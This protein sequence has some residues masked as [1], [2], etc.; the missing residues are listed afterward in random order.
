MG[1]GEPNGK[2]R[3]A[4]PNGGGGAS[5]SVQSEGAGESLLAALSG[6]EPSEDLV[7]HC[8]DNR[9]GLGVGCNGG[10]RFGRD[11]AAHARTPFAVVAQLAFL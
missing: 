5:E 8:L 1:D 11:L 10:T 3:M 6:V 9:F 2:W 7:R 4:M